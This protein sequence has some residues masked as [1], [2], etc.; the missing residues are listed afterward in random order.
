MYIKIIIQL[1]FSWKN[2]GTS[3]TGVLGGYSF[4]AESGFGTEVNSLSS[5]SE[6]SL[7]STGELSLESRKISILLELAHPILTG[8]GVTGRDCIP[9]IHD[10]FLKEVLKVH[11]RI[12]GE[13]D[14]FLEKNPFLRVESSV[15]GGDS[16]LRRKQS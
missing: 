3:L 7:I 1:A 9:Q 8:I 13:E 6:S 10:H 2:S 5:Y 15:P 11:R 16:N 4:N 14:H 12:H